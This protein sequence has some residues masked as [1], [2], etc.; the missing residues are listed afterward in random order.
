M[1]SEQVE[2]LIG[3]LIWS[4]QHPERA[5]IKTW[6]RGEA[7]EEALRS[8]KRERQNLEYLKSELEKIA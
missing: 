6:E 3:E 4:T 8:I 2:Q 5:T 7:V 1:T